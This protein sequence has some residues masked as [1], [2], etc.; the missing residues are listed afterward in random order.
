MQVT[1]QMR[2]A[3]ASSRAFHLG[4]LRR[5]WSMLSRE[6][7]GYFPTFEMQQ[8]QRSGSVQEPTSRE[9]LRQ[10]LDQL[11]KALPARNAASLPLAPNA[12]FT[13][14]AQQVPPTEG[15][16]ATA[17][18]VRPRLLEFLDPE[19]SQAGFMTVAEEHGQPVGLTARLRTAGGRINELE[20]IVARSGAPLF[21]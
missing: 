18:G 8:S 9:E 2:L 13:E 10:L 19:S 3:V 6:H 14:N 4:K 5:I 17:T 16:W 1:Y 12:R 11:A 7:I 21:N 15:I 20:L